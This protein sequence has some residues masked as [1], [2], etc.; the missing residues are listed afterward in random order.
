MISRTWVQL[1]LELKVSPHCL[2]YL[3]AAV[4]GLLEFHSDSYH[5]RTPED[6]PRGEPVELATGWVGM[7]CRAAVMCPT[8]LCSGWVYGH[9]AASPRS[10]PEIQLRVE[11]TD[12]LVWFPLS[13]VFSLEGD[14]LPSD[15]PPT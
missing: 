12:D 3:E 11:G 14:P 5:I 8:Y 15:S 4:A 9:R 6:P 2:P 1:A 13:R 10:E 7:G